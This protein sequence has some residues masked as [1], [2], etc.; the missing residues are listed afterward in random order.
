MFSSDFLHR[1]LTLESI[2]LVFQ[3]NGLVTV[4]PLIPSRPSTYGAKVLSVK[5]LYSKVCE[6]H[7]NV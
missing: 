7:Y 6:I 1:Q 3:L 5:K 2:L 4:I